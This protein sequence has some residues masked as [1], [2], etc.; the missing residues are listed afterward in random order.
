MVVC[1]DFQP[2]WDNDESNPG[3]Q[4]PEKNGEILPVVL[5]KGKEMTLKQ[6]LNLFTYPTE[7]P[8][9][10]TAYDL[11]QMIGNKD[12][13][14]K[15]K[16]YDNAYTNKFQEV[17]WALGAPRGDNFLSHM[18]FALTATTLFILLNG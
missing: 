13:I 3:Y 9:N 14:I 15:I 11:L 12:E 8:E 4:Y 16:T 2:L 1:K 7:I 6:D 18:V 17:Y 10:F 5:L